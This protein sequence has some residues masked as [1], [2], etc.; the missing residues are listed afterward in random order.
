MAQSPTTEQFPYTLTYLKQLLETDESEIIALSDA[1]RL[2]PQKEQ[3]TGK[4][5]YNYREV[6]MLRKALQMVNQ[7]KSLKSIQT[8]FGIGVTSV[9]TFADNIMNDDESTTMTD[10][11]NTSVLQQPEPST[12]LSS[13]MGR[14]ATNPQQAVVN[15]LNHDA[16]QLRSMGKDNV[17]VV[18]ES[19][20]SAREGMIKDMSRM[21][22]DKLAGLDEVVVE[23]IRCKSE[24]DAL[25]KK[26]EALTDDKEGLEFELARFTSTGFGFYRKS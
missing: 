5:I 20:A 17:A 16:R 25:K 10:S 9:S 7:G 19:I 1:L 13:S 18:V 6:Q 24:N 12:H 11:T 22:D 23:L 4:V 21:L 15:R 2:S 8:H 14:S 3:S 26:V